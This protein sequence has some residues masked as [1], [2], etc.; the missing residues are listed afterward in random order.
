[1][2]DQLGRSGVSEPLAI[3]HGILCGFAPE[4]AR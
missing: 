1:M 2:R 4:P 3:E